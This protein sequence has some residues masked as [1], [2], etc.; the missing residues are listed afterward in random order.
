MFSRIAIEPASEL[1]VMTGNLDRR[2]P[3]LALDYLVVYLIGFAVV[4]ELLAITIVADLSARPDRT[5]VLISCTPVLFLAI[6][7]GLWVRNSAPRTGRYREEALPV[8]ADGRSALSSLL[9]V[10]R[11]EIA[12]ELLFACLVALWLIGMG[13]DVDDIDPN[14]HPNRLRCLALTSAAATTASMALAMRCFRSFAIQAAMFLMLFLKGPIDYF[15]IISTFPSSDISSISS[16]V[17]FLLIFAAASLAIPLLVLRRFAFLP[18]GLPIAFG[19]LAFIVGIVA[20]NL[21][22]LLFLGLGRLILISAAVAAAY[23]WF[24]R[25]RLQRFEAGQL[26]LERRDP[27]GDTKLT[28]QISESM[29]GPA[30]AAKDMRKIFICYS[31]QDRK[32]IDRIQKMLHPLRGHNNV[33]I[34]DDSK[35]APGTNW[36][37]Q[38]Q[39][40]IEESSVAILLVSDSFLASDFISQVELP[41]LLRKR[42]EA[43]LHVIWLLLTECLHDT[44]PLREFQGPK[45]LAR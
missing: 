13:A 18:W 10:D 44:S 17:L 25:A 9:G 12:W 2:A 39:R 8:D 38:I 27:A 36:L 4:G 41:R 29:A 30:E 26:E 15:L 22:E 21:E 23:T 19:C 31:H 35:I 33:E 20:S 24:F 1:E 42:Q 14:I 34:W 45:V 11:K 28:K 32:W 40:A 37:A 5:D 3:N 7:V 6:A 43:N 16:Y